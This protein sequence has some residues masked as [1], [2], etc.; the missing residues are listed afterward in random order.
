MEKYHETEEGAETQENG[1]SFKMDLGK[2][3][4]KDDKAAKPNLEKRL[5]REEIIK[6]EI[7]FSHFKEFE[8]FI[9]KELRSNQD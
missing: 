2:S 7:R 6:E 5:I 8:I 3:A 9:K 1:H 4:E